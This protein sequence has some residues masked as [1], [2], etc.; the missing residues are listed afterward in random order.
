MNAGNPIEALSESIYNATLL[1]LPDIEYTHQTP[2][3][4]KEGKEGVIKKR[5]PYTDSVSVHLF[6]QTW[7]STALGFG[8]IGG[9][10]ITT[11]YT[12]VVV[13]PHSNYASVYFNGRHAY[14]K[15]FTRQMNIDMCAGRMVEVSKSHRYDSAT[16]KA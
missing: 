3:D 8:G 4:R 14:T 7:S 6:P 16:P 12:A 9:Q 2:Q 1:H 13:C 15:P 5:R 10:A 11:A